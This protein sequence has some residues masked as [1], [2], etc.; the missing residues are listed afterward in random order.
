MMYMWS[1]NEPELS[2][3]RIQEFV[4]PERNMVG[5]NVIPSNEI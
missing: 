5:W 3:A 2:F 4:I 1:H